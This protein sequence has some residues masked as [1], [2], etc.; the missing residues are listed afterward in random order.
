M[1]S[2]PMNFFCN[3]GGDDINNFLLVCYD[4]YDTYDSGDNDR[5]K[6]ENI[7][8]IVM[9]MTVVKIMKK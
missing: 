9:M 1:I 6:Y 2:L 3:S 7:K 4:N 5:N 8:K